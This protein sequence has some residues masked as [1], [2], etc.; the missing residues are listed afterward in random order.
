MDIPSNPLLRR[1]AASAYLRE[2][3]GIGRAPATLAKLAV[4][5]GGPRFRRAGR[6]PLYAPADLNAWAAAL[7]GEPVASTSAPKGDK[8][9]DR[10]GDAVA[11]TG[12]AG[13]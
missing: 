4:V 13:R 12:R 8:P 2:T 6:V 1:A 9:G 7:L 3:W 11:L 5:G 10:R